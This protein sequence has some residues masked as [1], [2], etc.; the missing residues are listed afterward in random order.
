MH[1]DEHEFIQFNKQP[2]KKLVLMTK[3]QNAGQYLIYGI[4]V[5]MVIFVLTFI[6]AKEK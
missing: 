1:G 3:H 4:F 6:D 5:R 2:S